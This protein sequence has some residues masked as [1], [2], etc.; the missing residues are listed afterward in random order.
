MRGYRQFGFIGQTNILFGPAFRRRRVGFLPTPTSSVCIFSHMRQVR[1]PVQPHVISRHA[2]EVCLRSYTTNT[3]RSGRRCWQGE[4]SGREVPLPP[5]PFHRQQLDN[6]FTGSTDAGLS[7]R[8]MPEWFQ[9]HMRDGVWMDPRWPIHD[10]VL[11]LGHTLTYFSGRSG[12][13]E[14]GRE[15]RFARPRRRS[16]RPSRAGRSPSSSRA[17]RRRGSRWSKGATFGL[18]TV[19]FVLCKIWVCIQLLLVFCSIGHDACLD[20]EL[21]VRQP[22]RASIGGCQAFGVFSLETQ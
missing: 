19:F 18:G 9:V 5:R 12:P 3:H 13:K 22:Q 17:A 1:E 8:S 11:T 2:C 4:C 6:R 16:A 7:F 14:I 21:T 20:D 10:C 15:P